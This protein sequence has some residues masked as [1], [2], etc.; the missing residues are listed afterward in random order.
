GPGAALHRG[1][2]SP[3]R[4]RRGVCAGAPQR[5]PRALVH[6]VRGR[7]RPYGPPYPPHHL[8]RGARCGEAG[9][10]LAGVVRGRAGSTVHGPSR[11]ACDAVRNGR[12]AAA[13]LLNPTKVRDVFAVADAGE[14][15]PPKSTYFVPKVPSGLV[16]RAV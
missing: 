4:D 16:I 2:P 7:S 11:A 3:L 12:A 8:R 1:R 10:G 15:M 14:V 9:R 6:R 5:R 13:V